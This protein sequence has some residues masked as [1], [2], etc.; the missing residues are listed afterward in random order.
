M[1][2]RY[3]AL[4]TRYAAGRVS[5]RA[6]LLTLGTVG[7]AALTGPTVTEA[8]KKK[9]KQS[10]GEKARQKCQKQVGQCVAF[11]TPTCDGDLDCQAQVRRCCPEVGTCD[12]VGLFTCV[13]AP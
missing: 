4:L 8:R 7:V 1:N 12:V 10:A 3:V 2:D 9:R 6:S 11:L 5:R 13:S